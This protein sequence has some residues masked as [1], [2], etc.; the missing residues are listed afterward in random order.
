MAQLTRHQLGASLLR[1]LRQQGLGVRDL[2]EGR[3]EPLSWLFRA[4]A[5]DQSELDIVESGAIDALHAPSALVELVLDEMALGIANIGLEGL[6]SYLHHDAPFA[7]ERE[8]GGALA[9]RSLNPSVMLG[10]LNIDVA[11]PALWLDERNADPD[12]NE[13]LASSLARMAQEVG[14]GADSVE[15]HIEGA[16]DA[17]QGWVE[18]PSNVRPAGVSVHYTYD[19]PLPDADERKLAAIF[20]R[21]GA[22]AATA[23]ERMRDVFRRG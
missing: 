15:V 12:A 6:A 23:I 8:E 13:Q 3:Q 20:T 19:I 1:A 14:G 21:G 16:L 9:G 18:A 4:L 11:P 17:G 5:Y 22:T 2:F 10:Y 7:T